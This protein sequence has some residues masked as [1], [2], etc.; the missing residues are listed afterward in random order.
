MLS[1]PLRIESV[2]IYVMDYDRNDLII[3]TDG[4]LFSPLFG[5]QSNSP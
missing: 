2:T 4:E 5:G 3:T 1:F